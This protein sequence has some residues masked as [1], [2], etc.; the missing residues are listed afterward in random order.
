LRLGTGVS[1][2]IVYLS[3]TW[4]EGATRVLTYRSNAGITYGA[5]TLTAPTSSGGLASDDVLELDFAKQYIT[6]VAASGTRTDAADWRASGAW[7]GFDPADGDA[8]ADRWPTL[9]TSTGAGVVIYRE[10]F[11]E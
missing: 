11:E 3:G 2:G 6:K 5:L 4:A 10:V 8:T 9:Q 1:T 7:F